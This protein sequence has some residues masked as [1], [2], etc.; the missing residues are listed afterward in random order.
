VEP[1]TKFRGGI[2][3]LFSGS[4]ISSCNQPSKE[5][6]NVRTLQPYSGGVSPSSDTWRQCIV[7]VLRYT[8]QSPTQCTHPPLLIKLRK[9]SGSLLW[10]S[11]LLAPTQAIAR[12]KRG[13]RTVA[14][15]AAGSYL[16]HQP[17]TYRIGKS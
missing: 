5:S 15:L 4:G 6:W 10:N 7:G 13:K 17:N 12:W 16:V 3:S 1:Y 2:I 9:L 8:P 14:S 11:R